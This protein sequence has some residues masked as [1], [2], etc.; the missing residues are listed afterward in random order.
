EVRQLQVLVRGAHRNAEL[1]LHA[2]AIP[3]VVA[4]LRVA[5]DSPSV[6]RLGDSLPVTVT[7]V[8]PYGNTFPAPLPRLSLGDTTVASIAGS[9]VIGGPRR[10]ST[11]LTVISD[12]VTTRVP[13]KV[14]QYVASIVLNNL[15]WRSEEHT[16]ELKSRSDL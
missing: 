3:H 2:R 14:V 12:Y 13:L 7:A 6:L 8:D 11:E 15:Q 10:G 16:S 1:T 4:Q 9:T 5:V